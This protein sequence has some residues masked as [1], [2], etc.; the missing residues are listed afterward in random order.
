ML[1]ILIIMNTLCSIL[2][3]V[4]MIFQYV[5]PLSHS[6]S[7]YTDS[8]KSSTSTVKE[9]NH[10]FNCLLKFWIFDVTLAIVMMLCSLIGESYLI[11][12]SAIVVLILAQRN[13][14]EGIEQIYSLV[15]INAMKL[16]EAHLS[17][18]I[19]YVLEMIRSGLQ[20]SKSIIL[21]QILSRIFTALLNKAT[22]KTE[23]DLNKF[24]QDRKE[25]DELSPA[26]PP[27][28]D[29]LKYD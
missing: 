26:S 16:Y 20:Y 10:Y 24:N 8:G 6:F 7:A 11:E 3:I 21:P 27:E 25:I 23:R 28:S 15:I 18:H 12:G 2:A 14:Y 29:E 17:R 5:V 1:Y 13:R 19:D 22:S 4:R 9:S